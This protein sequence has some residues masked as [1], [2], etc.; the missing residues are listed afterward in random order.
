MQGF[1]RFIQ[2]RGLGALLAMA[3][4]SCTLP[5]TADAA[6]RRWTP[7]TTAT[8]TTTPLSIS[9][10]PAT[11]VLAGSTYSFLPTTS[12]GGSTKTY[13]VANK[14]A[15]ASFSVSTGKLS[16]APGSAS[17]G[18]YANVTISVSDGTSKSSL[19]PFGINV[20]APASTTTTT[21][22]T[23]PVPATTGS[24]TL[25]WTAPSQ[26][27]DGST[28]SDLAGYYVY[29]GSSASSLINR[30]AVPDPGSS[31]YTVASLASGTY[32]FGLAAY[33]TA[34]VES[35]LSNIGSKTIN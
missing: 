23:T 10:T 6:R 34:G 13:S 5:D 2:C 4:L 19:A 29:Y 12:G 3:M 27:T 1:N 28:L 24:A 33:N 21:T 11:S 20:N 31:S 22:T 14:P 30:I 15:W 8:T 25:A 26:N 16:G 7:T 9:G 18:T 35:A 32:Y 17:V